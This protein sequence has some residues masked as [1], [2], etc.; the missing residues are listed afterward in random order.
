MCV[1]SVPKTRISMGFVVVGFPG[2]GDDA[3]SIFVLPLW[4]GVEGKE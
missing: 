3:V 1:N 4:E 2:F